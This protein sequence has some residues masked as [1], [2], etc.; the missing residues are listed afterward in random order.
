MGVDWLGF[1]VDK[2]SINDVPR[3]MGAFRDREG[4]LNGI[5]VLGLLPLV[6]SELTGFVKGTDHAYDT[7]FSIT[8]KFLG[9]VTGR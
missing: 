1:C 9:Q 8:G 4:Q 6:P 3:Q 7:N 5:A 2:A